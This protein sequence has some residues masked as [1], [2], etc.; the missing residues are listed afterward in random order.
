[1]GRLASGRNYPAVLLVGPLFINPVA[2]WPNLHLYS[3]LVCH[4]VPQ[5]HPKESPAIPGRGSRPATPPNGK[6]G[7]KEG[8][9]MVGELPGHCGSDLISAAPPCP[10]CPSLVRAAPRGKFRIRFA[11]DL[12][13]VTSNLS[14]FRSFSCTISA[15]PNSHSFPGT[16]SLGPRKRLDL[17]S[18]SSSRNPSAPFSNP[19]FCRTTAD[20]VT[21][22]ILRR[23]THSAPARPVCHRG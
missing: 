18:R 16:G 8:E 12:Q 3:C 23:D 20:P 2:H 4:P 7:P 19:Q 6:T 1:V 22:R 11:I 21:K 5:T 17:A 15:E 10:C 13:P 9:K 14:L